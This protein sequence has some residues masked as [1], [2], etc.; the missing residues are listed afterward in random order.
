MQALLSGPPM[1]DH[2]AAAAAG[3]GAAA[4]SLQFGNITLPSTIEGSVDTLDLLPDETAIPG[5][6]ASG[7]EGAW[8]C[9]HVREPGYMGWK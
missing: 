1:N 7:T 9:M 5:A 4:G 3:T 2:A 8:A 6:A